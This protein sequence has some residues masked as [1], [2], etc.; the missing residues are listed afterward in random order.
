MPVSETEDGERQLCCSRCSLVYGT[1]ILYATGTVGLAFIKNGNHYN[2][3]G[4]TGANHKVFIPAYHNGLPVLG[5]NA[6]ALSQKHHVT[7]LEIAEGV[8]IIGQAAFLQTPLFCVT[9]PQSI[10]RIDGAAFSQTNLTSFEVPV[11]VVSLS[12][13][14]F[15]GTGL[16]NLTVAEGNTRY[17]SY[18][19]SVI[20]TVSDTLIIGTKNSV[21]ADY[22]SG[23]GDYAFNAIVGLS[24]SFF[25]S[26][27]TKGKRK[28]GFA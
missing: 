5:V 16:S 24:D 7:H 1:E 12:P 10:T 11:S 2:V 17:H 25:A 20:E 8:Q 15:S 27:E 21:I 19:N 4:Y 26:L 22:V 13:A 6:Y 23:I 3:S 18:G 14:V 28:S 9:L